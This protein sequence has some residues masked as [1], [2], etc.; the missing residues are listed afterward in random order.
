MPR[1]SPLGSG[2]S[3]RTTSDACSI[4]FEGIEATTVVR[5]HDEC[6]AEKVKYMKE[7]EIS[8]PKL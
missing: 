3:R 1:R 8:R 4:F 5:R 6:G 2:R 7:S